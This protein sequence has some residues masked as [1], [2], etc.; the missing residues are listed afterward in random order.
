MA[1]F[2]AITFTQ[3]I[4]DSLPTIT[5][6][7]Q[8]R[9]NKPYLETFKQ[10]DNQPQLAVSELTRLFQTYTVGALPI[11]FS[12]QSTTYGRFGKELANS[13]MFHRY[14]GPFQV[15]DACYLEIVALN[16]SLTNQPQ[17]INY[18]SKKDIRRTRYNLDV[19][20]DWCGTHTE[21]MDFIPK[22]RQLDIDLGMLENKLGYIVNEYSYKK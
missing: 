20:A 22:L 3:Y 11:T 2:D 6:D 10:L 8:L 12:D 19:M 4:M 14:P 9:I 5:S 16:W 13:D 21:Y 7:N 1:D 18:T 15:L 17:F